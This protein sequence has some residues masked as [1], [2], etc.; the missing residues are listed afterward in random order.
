MSETLFFGVITFLLVLGPLVILHELG[1]LWTARR[2]GVK[3]LEFGFGYPPRAAG[4]WTGNTIIGVN[5]DT[6]YERDAADLH[7]TVVAIKTVIGGNRE[8]TAISIRPMSSGDT[9]EAAA[10]GSITVGKLKSSISN[11]ISYILFAE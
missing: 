10:G 6:V 11:T 3:T 7:G 1:H 4:F 5:S 9:A 2:F 8:L